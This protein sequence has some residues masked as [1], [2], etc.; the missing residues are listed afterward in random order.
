MALKPAKAPVKKPAPAA[1]TTDLGQTNETQLP[2]IPEGE[3]GNELPKTPEVEVVYTVEPEDDLVP[4]LSVAQSGVRPGTIVHIR[5]IFI[6]EMVSKGEI[7]FLP[8]EE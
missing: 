8:D 5:E 7:T 2:T 6:E 1:T 4:M 3:N